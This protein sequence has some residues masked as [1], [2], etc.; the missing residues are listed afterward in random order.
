MGLAARAGV[1]AA[2]AL[3]VLAGCAGKGVIKAPEGVEPG[4]MFAKQG[5][6]GEFAALA[7][8]NEYVLVGEGHTI[9][10]DHKVQA[11]V[12]ESMAGLGP[13]VGLEMVSEDRQDVLDR[14]NAGEMRIGELR[15]ALNW[16][17]TW[18]HPFRLYVPVFGAAR[19]HGLDL[20]ALNAPRSVISA[21]SDG[22][23]EAVPGGE[24]KYLPEKVIA[25]APE[26][27]EEL[28]AVYEAHAPKKKE[29]DEKA[30]SFER[31]MLVQSLWDTVMAGNAVRVRRE[32]GG[33]VIVLAGAGHVE[34]GLGI[35]RRIKALEP[36][37]STL[38]VTPWR[39][40][41][42]VE[43]AAGDV[44]FYCPHTHAAKGGYTLAFR[45]EGV[46]IDDVDPG[47][48]AEA[49][50]FRE[51]DRVA[52]IEGERIEGP[53]DIFRA[54]LRARRSGGDVAFLLEREGGMAVVELIPDKAGNEDAGT[55]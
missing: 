5:R 35:A 13:A 10:C 30:G 16:D 28:R 21:V 8:G 45:Q 49:A 48:Q 51:G 7:A 50:G 32:T 55:P 1:F 22:G 9:F 23:I 31:F 18:G 37:A 42:D 27:V 29:G 54:L 40:M 6:G 20:Y 11:A 43:A 41:G 4:A 39:G 33:P 19:K 36:D 3:I 53:G 34:Y 46:F 52:G 25:P 14:F 47:S 26:Q 2:M 44:F 12:I 17:K 24:R 38:T 15:E